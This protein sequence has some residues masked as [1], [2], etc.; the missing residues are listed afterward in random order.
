[1]LLDVDSALMVDIDFPDQQYAAYRTGDDYS[2][3]PFPDGAL[4]TTLRDPRGR[5]RTYFYLPQAIDAIRAAAS[6]GIDVVWNTN[7]L[8]DEERVRQVAT[9]IGLADDVRFP[10]DDELPVRPTDT[11]IDFGPNCLWEHWKVQALVER[12]R[13]SA[14]GCE[15]VLV[16][17]DLDY[18]SR[19]LSDGVSRRA[20]RNDAIVGWIHPKDELGLDDHDAAAIV[21]WAQTGTLPG[22]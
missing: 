7:W 1:M 3:Q 15:I 4:T 10:T 17:A 2:P 22:H 13:T 6:A 19:R 12:V 20:K 5:A 8:A 14:T 9:E 18:S 11:R 21:G 16:D